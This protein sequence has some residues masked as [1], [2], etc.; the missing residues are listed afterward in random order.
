VF[1]E[2]ETPKE[3]EKLVR[4]FD[5]STKSERELRERVADLEDLLVDLLNQKRSQKPFRDKGKAKQ[6]QKGLYISARALGI[7]EKVLG[8]ARYYRNVH[9]KQGNVEKPSRRKLEV[10]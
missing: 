4:T 7:M 8:G 3:P 1:K 9:R 5:V 10:E 6:R 2:S